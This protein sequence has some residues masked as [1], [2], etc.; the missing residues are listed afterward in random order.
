MPA[1]ML[2]KMLDWSNEKNSFRVCKKL[3]W[4]NAKMRKRREKRSRKNMT[5]RANLQRPVVP[6]SRLN[7]KNCLVG[8]EK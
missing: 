2:L 1:N 6:V 3:P 8:D 5:A 4:V 7:A